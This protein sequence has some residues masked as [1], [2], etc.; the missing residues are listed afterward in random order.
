MSQPE[1]MR[2]PKYVDD[3]G[4]QPI[5]FTFKVKPADNI[6]DTDCLPNDGTAYT[7]NTNTTEGGLTCQMWSVNTPHE[8][9]YNH[10]GENNYC[11]N[12][13]EAERPWCYTTDPGIRW[14]FCEIPFCAKPC[15]SGRFKDGSDY[16]GHVNTT[17]TGQPCQIWPHDYCRNC[18]GHNYCRNP[19]GQEK[20]WCFTRD[21]E[22]SWEYCD[23]SACLTGKQPTED[24]GCQ[25][26]NGTAYTG[27]ANSTDTGRA[28]QMWCVN[29]P[30]LLYEN[31][32]C[33]DPD[34]AGK[35]GCYV[36]DPAYPKEW[37]FCDVPYC[38]KDCNIN[39]GIHHTLCILLG[40][41]FGVTF[42]Q[43]TKSMYNFLFAWQDPKK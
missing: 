15:H 10:L 43:Q 25:P 40:I 2:S 37:A 35:L 5:N 32:Y 39:S 22:I 18:G 30:E 27:K 3:I 6:D 9:K 34:G 7:G 41:Q 31:N 11:R 1:N 4:C 8:H 13:S 29:R 14:K 17:K 12:P 21:P 16:A 23:I 19:R 28:C 42:R 33:R 24:I 20:P 36:T 26:Q 38:E